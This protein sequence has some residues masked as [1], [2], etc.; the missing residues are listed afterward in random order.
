MEVSF[1]KILVYSDIHSSENAVGLLRKDAE[2]YSPDL[3][4]LLGDITHFGPRS[5]AE[6]F[7]SSTKVRTLAIPGNCDT[8]DVLGLLEEKGISLHGKREKVGGFDFVGFGGSN[9]TPFDTITEFS[10]DDIL[11]ALDAVMVKGAVLVTHVPPRG[12]VDGTSS[13]LHVGSTA[14][15]KIVEKYR[16]RVSLS[17]HVHEARGMVEEEG[18]LFL[19]PGP[20]RKGYRAIVD[21]AES[22][23]EAMLLD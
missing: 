18:T 19:N 11:S 6:E 13:G 2:S 9:L 7:I 5:F 14:V 17:G 8:P 15:A 20:V 21:L 23:V 4:L 12:H 10:E 3:L 1:M 16:P 22:D